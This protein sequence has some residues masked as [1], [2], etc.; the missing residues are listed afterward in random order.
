MVANLKEFAELVKPKK[1]KKSDE[2][3]SKTSLKKKLA[4]W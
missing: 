1:K 4:T 2:E 3:K